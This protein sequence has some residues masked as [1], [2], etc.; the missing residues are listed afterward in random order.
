MYPM[1]WAVV[2]IEN[3]DAW[4]WFLSTFVMEDVSGLSF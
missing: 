3:Y 1:A 4:Y 2:A